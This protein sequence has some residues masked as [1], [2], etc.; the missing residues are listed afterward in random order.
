ME[1]RDFNTGM[2]NVET[3]VGGVGNVGPEQKSGTAIKDKVSGQAAEM[4]DKLT[5]Q[6]KGVK[7]KVMT[8]ANQYGEQ[9]VT[10][11][12]STRERTAEGLK[13]TSQRIDRLAMYIQ[14]HDSRQMSEALINNSQQ[15]IR[16]NPGKSLVFGLVAGMLL[17]RIFSGFGGGHH[18]ARY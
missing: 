1:N 8:Q 14:E 2:N 10:K 18:K 4:K 15:Y 13:S 7:E 17:G 5:E 16:Q 3:G 9:L 11:I 6:A 12:D